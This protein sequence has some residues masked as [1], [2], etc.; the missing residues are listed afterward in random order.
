MKFIFIFFLNLFFLTHFLYCKEEVEKIV[1]VD[2]EKILEVFLQS[3]KFEKNILK[4]KKDAHQIAQRKKNKI[5]KLSDKL[6]KER[7]L[8]PDDTIENLLEEIDFLE[9]DLKEYLA[10][11]KKKVRQIKKK[12]KR[13]LLNRIDYY[14][15]K[16][17]K[18]K[19][20]SLILE[21]NSSFY[22]VSKDLNATK[23]VIQFIEK[24][25]ETDRFN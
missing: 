11:K 15:K 14:L 19:K 5:E 2:V 10:E 24:E 23:Q 20:Y 17:A 1:Y 3:T 9:E 7:K 25:I 22:Y 21:K 4:I 13:S 18:I 6:E 16:I 8:L 12:Y